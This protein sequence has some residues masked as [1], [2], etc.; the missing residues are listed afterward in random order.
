MRRRQGSSGELRLKCLI[1]VNISHKLHIINLAKMF[2]FS[3]F[4]IVH[5][6]LCSCWI[7]LRLSFII[8]C[9][10]L[11]RLLGR[12]H[13]HYYNGVDYGVDFNDSSYVLALTEG[14]TSMRHHTV[15]SYW[16]FGF[17]NCFR[18]FWCVR[19]ANKEVS[20]QCFSGKYKGGTRVA[21][22]WSFLWFNT[23]Y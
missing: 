14:I 10:G 4:S 9:T 18:G 7:T 2:C 23:I 12:F 16:H 15:F 1:A 8:C 13:H 22:R 19:N 6:I 20:A 11:C 21:R 3:W 5:Q 17:A